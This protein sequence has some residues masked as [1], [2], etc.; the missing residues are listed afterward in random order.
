MK[1]LHLETLVDGHRETL[2]VGL[3]PDGEMPIASVRIEWGSDRYCCL[4]AFFVHPDF[5]RLGMGRR[6]AR[7][8][9]QVADDAGV[10]AIGI[11]IQEKNTVAVDFWKAM[12]FG[13]AG[14]NPD[15]PE[16]FAAY[17]YLNSLRKA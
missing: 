16:D 11:S 8:A 14:R 17:L 6:L 2:L 13:M 9:I 1:I 15:H 7:R 5:R 10:T 12:G 4:I 3:A